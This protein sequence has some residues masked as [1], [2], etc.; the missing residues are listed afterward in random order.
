[1]PAGSAAAFSGI[2]AAIFDLDGT[3]IDSMGVW[4]KIDADFLAKR[5][6]ALPDDYAAKL[7]ALGFREAAEYTIERFGFQES[8][9]MLI[10]EWNAM[11]IDEYTH[12]I[13]LKPH[14][15]EYLMELKERGIKLGVATSLHPALYEAVLK[16]NGVYDYFD[17]IC[18]TGEVARGKE[19]PDVFLRAAELMNTAPGSCLVFED[20]LQ[21]MRAAKLAGMKICGVFDASSNAH[22]EE[23]QRLADGVILDFKDAPRL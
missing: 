16:N 4:G 3:L 10:D 5:G 23:I 1:M 18:S 21:A 7:S 6:I 11:A 9:D 14:A 12:R 19:F 8:A 20:L 22:W 13:A 2:K 15:K 17:V